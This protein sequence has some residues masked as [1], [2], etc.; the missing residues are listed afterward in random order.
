MT[1]F[2]LVLSNIS[3]KSVL[4]WWSSAAIVFFLSLLSVQRGEPGISGQAGFVGIPSTCAR[5]LLHLLSHPSFPEDHQAEAAGAGEQ[6]LLSE[7][8]ISQ[9]EPVNSSSLL[10]SFVFVCRTSWRKLRKTQRGR[11]MPS[12]LIISWRRW[13]AIRWTREAV[14]MSL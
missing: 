7:L 4:S 13:A 6:Q 2:I 3:V 8:N 10:F 11:K 14:M 12:K 9:H 1:L 5:P